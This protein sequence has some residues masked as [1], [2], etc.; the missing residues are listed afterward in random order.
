MR[1]TVVAIAA[2]IVGASALV[3]QAPA[4]TPEVRPFAGVI[5]PTGAQR[6][7]F[8]DAAL[9]GMQAAV[10]LK[11]SLHLV[12]TFGW[13][14]GQ[15]K[16]NVSLDNV[17]IFQYNAG[18]ELGFVEPLAG[19]WELRPFIGAGVGGRSYTYE[20]STLKDKTSFAGYGALGTEFQLARTALRLE[21]RDNVFWFRSPIAG[22]DT[23]TRNDI[24][25]SLGVAYHLR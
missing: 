23:D 20:A 7:L 22:V 11:P 21:V 5:V 2:L 16:Y 25:F 13:T 3:A 19:N 17:N 24:G 4:I 18:I 15:D 1:R 10:E 14:P 12:G 8:A 6:D 9:V